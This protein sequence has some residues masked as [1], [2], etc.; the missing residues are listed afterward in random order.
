M[1]GKNDSYSAQRVSPEPIQWSEDDWGGGAEWHLTLPYMP[2]FP[3]PF[4]I[5]LARTRLKHDP[6]GHL[7]ADRTVH[8]FNTGIIEK[9][10]RAGP[11]ARVR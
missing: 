11:C 5:V 2:E 9:L 8:V 10:V 3:Y 7:A 1:S 6:V 4:T